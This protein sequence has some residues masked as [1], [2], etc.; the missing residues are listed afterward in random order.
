MGCSKGSSKREVYS[1]TSL[2]QEIRKSSNKLTSH[3][4]QLERE[5]QT[6]PKISRRK[7]IIKIE[8][9]IKKIEIK[10]TIEE[11]NKIKSLFFEKVNKIDKL[12][13]DSPRRGEKKTQI[14]TIRNEKGESQQIL[15]KYKNP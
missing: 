13:L 12:W 1:N 3:P 10:K 7:E 14:N 5:E 2:P 6:R 15:L 4:K 9:E 8:E 11:I